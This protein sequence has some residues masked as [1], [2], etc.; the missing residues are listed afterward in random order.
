VSLQHSPA[1]LAVF[2]GPTSTGSE[3]NGGG[4]RKGKGEGRERRWR[5]E[6]GPPKILGVASLMKTVA[7]KIS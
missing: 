7:G 3:G 1:P 4:R 6:I 5:E 2:K